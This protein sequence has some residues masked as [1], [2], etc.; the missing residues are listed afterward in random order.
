MKKEP[1]RNRGN[2]KSVAPHLIPTE[3]PEKLFS[4]KTYYENTQTVCSIGNR[5]AKKNRTQLF[6]LFRAYMY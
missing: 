5:T 6:S 2:Y 4:M 1:A 3:V